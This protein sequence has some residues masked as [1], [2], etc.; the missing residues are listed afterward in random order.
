MKNLKLQHDAL[1]YVEHPDH[2]GSD[3]I[4]VTGKMEVCQECGGTGSH[5]RKDLDDS[6]MVDDMREDGNE[7]GLRAYFNGA[8]DERC[9]VCDGANVV[10]APDPDSVPEWAQDAIDSW[11]Q[12]RWES[13]EISRQERRM[14][15]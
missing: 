1:S 8:F 4:M 14:G 13:E 12:S 2:D 10:L 9:R 15:A 7:E 6:Q 5:V 3:F 11:N